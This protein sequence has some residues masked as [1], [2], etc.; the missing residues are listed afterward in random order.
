MYKTQ[1]KERL[2]KERDEELELIVQRLECES[3]SSSGDVHKRY[4]IQ[5]EKLKNQTNDEI[6]QVKHKFLFNPLL[7]ARD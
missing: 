4:Q 7:R 2:L 5:I 6:K 1:L 3:S